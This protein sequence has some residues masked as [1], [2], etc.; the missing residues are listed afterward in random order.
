MINLK[1][2]MQRFFLYFLRFT[3]TSTNKKRIFLVETVSD[4]SIS[5]SYNKI[6]KI[7]EDIASTLRDKIQEN[8][9]YFLFPLSQQ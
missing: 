1:Q 5:I 6:L 3:I 2:V 8:N 9:V 4:F 7:K